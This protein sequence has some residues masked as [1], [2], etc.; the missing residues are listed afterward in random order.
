MSKKI[1]IAII[2]ILLLVIGFLI[3]QRVGGL[4]ISIG[5]GNKGGSGGG[6]EQV[7]KKITSA[8]LEMFPAGTEMKPGLIGKQTDI[9]KGGNMIALSGEADISGKMTLALQIFDSEGNIF[10]AGGPGMSMELKGSGGF[11]M[12]CFSPPAETGKYTL[13][14]LLDNQE[15]KII[16][17]EVVK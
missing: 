9:F 1:L 12:C 2:I 6:Q 3:I 11:G 10:Q 4:N 17:F 13:K 5:L 7:A 16:P 14:L 8:H 15:E